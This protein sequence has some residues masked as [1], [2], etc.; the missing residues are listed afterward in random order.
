MSNLGK[1]NAGR[2]LVDT[3][4]VATGI[5]VRNTFNA[6][7]SRGDDKVLP[8]VTSNEGNIFEGRICDK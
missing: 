2:F 3:S 1:N 8:A 7:V 4:M 6:N 5:V